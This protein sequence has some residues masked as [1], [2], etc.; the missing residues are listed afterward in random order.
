MPSCYPLF[1]RDL[2][3]LPIP[4]AMQVSCTLTLQVL[5]ADRR[6][7]L[8]RAERCVPRN[9]S[10][11]NLMPTDRNRSS[12][13]RSRGIDFNPASY[14]LPRTQRAER[15]QRISHHG[16]ADPRVDADPEDAIHHEIG[17][18]QLANDAVGRPLVGR[19][20]R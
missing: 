19:L 8:R 7:R 17:V 2:G 4:F 18:G 6:D 1:F 3:G 14:D 5:Q 9:Q 16:L 10:L 11:H 12:P 20:A 13:R 15:L